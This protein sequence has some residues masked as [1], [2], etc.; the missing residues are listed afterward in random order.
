MSEKG[1][2]VQ[3]RRIDVMTARIEAVLLGMD[4]AL[5]DTEQIYLTPTFTR[6]WRFWANASLSAHSL[7]EKM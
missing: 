2:G 6:D 3:L 5:L 7:P 4:G 1:S